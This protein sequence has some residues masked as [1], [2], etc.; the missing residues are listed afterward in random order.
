MTFSEFQ[1]TEQLLFKVGT[2]M[3]P[4]ET[5]LK[6]P[7]RLIKIK[8]LGYLRPCTHPNLVSNPILLKLCRRKK[9]A[10]LTCIDPYYIPLLDLAKSKEE[11]S[12]SLLM[13]VK[14]ESGKASLKLNI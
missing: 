12:R 2:V 1:K 13:R 3:N 6:G 14:E 9:N 8:R 7:E 4:P 10:R 11:A 5:R